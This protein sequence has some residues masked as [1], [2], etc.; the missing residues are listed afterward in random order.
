[1]LGCEFA[2]AL[3]ELH[4][5]N[6]HPACTLQERFDNNGGN[7][8]SSLLQQL[9]QRVG[10]LNVAALT[11]LPYRTAMAIRRMYPLHR[12]TQRSKRLS[13]NRIGAGRHGAHGISVI[14][15]F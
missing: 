15:M 13:K 2:N 4:R 1:M 5:M 9:C 10:A 12:K 14:S 6:N 8:V 7:L 11:P 3:Q